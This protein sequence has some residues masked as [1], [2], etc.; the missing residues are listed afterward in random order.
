MKKKTEN[1]IHFQDGDINLT[2]DE[3]ERIK[4]P[5]NAVRLRDLREAFPDVDLT[6]YQNLSDLA[7]RYTE[8]S[9]EYHCIT[10]YCFDCM[11]E[12]T[13]KRKIL[14]RAICDFIS[15]MTDTYALNEYRKLEY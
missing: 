12:Y 13:E 7:S 11:E 5:E 8:D 1:A 4:H 10:D 15:G 9:N 14:V 3:W 6:E 2:N